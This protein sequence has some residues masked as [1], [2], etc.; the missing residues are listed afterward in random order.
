MSELTYGGIEIVFSPY[1]P[2]WRKMRKVCAREMMSSK[3]LDSY[4]GL[5]R[6]EV[7]QMVRDVR[8][9]ACTTVN[10]GELVF[11]LAL[12]VVMN[13]IWGGTLDGEGRRKVG[14]EFQRVINEAIE[15]VSEPNLSDFFPI[16]SRFDV[17]GV[18]GRMK[19]LTSWMDKI[20]ESVLDQRLKMDR[21]EGGKESKDFLQLLLQ[22]KEE[23]D[24]KTPLTLTNIK[25]IFVDLVIA[26]TDTTSTTIE[27]AMA[28]MLQNPE[29]MRKVQEELEQVVGM[30]SMVEESHVRRLRYLDAVIKEALR[31]HPP[32]VFLV[33]RY[34][35]QTCT[36]GGYTLP[37]G[38]QIVINTWVIRRDPEAWDN[39]LEF[40]PERF[41]NSTS[42]WDYNGNDFGYLP[43]G[44]GRRICVGLPLAE[45][46]LT[47]EL[48]SLLHS[49]NWRL[50]DDAKL[51]LS[52]KY[53]L[54]MKKG[55]PLIAIPTPRLSNPELYS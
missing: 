17:Q 19:K 43:F 55:T 32:L 3:V 51:D 7:R 42:K 30:D 26:G 20:F 37:K 9:L 18:V 21:G 16:L 6:L 35:S 2:N 27:W 41:Y 50:P 1:D 48:A 54:I 14:L 53:A 15:L 44:S 29:I 13:M 12:N 5:R 11:Q 47:Y 34:P 8:T 39:P 49:F 40:C 4:Y 31:L 38:T 28:E 24:T 36:V 46:M 23:G 25:A 10:I 52:E 45:R 33:P 22:L